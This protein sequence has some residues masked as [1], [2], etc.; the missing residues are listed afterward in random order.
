VADRLDLVSAA[1]AKSSKSEKPTKE[2]TKE[3]YALATLDFDN[4]KHKNSLPLHVGDFLLVLDDESDSG[5]TFV[6]KLP[7]DGSSKGKDAKVETGYVPTWAIKEIPK[8]SGKDTAKA[9]AEKK[10]TSK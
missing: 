1:Q 4:A 5:W 10:G 9:M 7:K 3:I 6:Q 2:L 8:G